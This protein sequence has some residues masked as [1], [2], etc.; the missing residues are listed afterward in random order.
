MGIFAWPASA[1]GAPAVARAAGLTPRCGRRV[2]AREEPRD[3]RDRGAGG[4]AAPATDRPSEGAG[5]PTAPRI[6]AAA[7]GQEGVEQDARGTRSDSPSVH[8]TVR[9][10]LGAAPGSLASAHGRH[11]VD[12]AVHAADEGP[13]SRRARAGTRT[14][15]WPALDRG[16]RLE[17]RARRDL[18]VGAVGP[19]A[20]TAPPPKLTIIVVARLARL[21]R[22]LAR[23]ALRRSTKASSLKLGVEAEVHLAQ[24]EVAE[25]VVAVLVGERE[26]LDHVAHRLGHL[27]PAERPVAVHVEPAVERDTRRPSAWSA[28]R[29]RAASGCPCRSGA[30][31]APRA[32]GTSRRRG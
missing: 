21:P 6:F 11:R 13:R 19:G 3:L 17:R 31:R 26:G 18:L 15:A 24:Q 2:D 5:A 20:G 30:R 22:S 28:S 1:L 8:S 16:P 23:S 14:P 25:G 10:A 7:L 32:R 9:E 4:K 12:V 27:P 29:R